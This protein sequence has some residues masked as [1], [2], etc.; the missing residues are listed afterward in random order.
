MLAGLYLAFQQTSYFL[1]PGNHLVIRDVST[2]SA[3]VVLLT[4]LVLIAGPL[5]SVA[6]AW[7]SWKRFKDAPAAQERHLRRPFSALL[8]VAVLDVTFVVFSLGLS[9]L[10]SEPGI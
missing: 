2:T 4:V 10:N 6:L 1:L 9:A 5:L 3:L 7:S 8:P